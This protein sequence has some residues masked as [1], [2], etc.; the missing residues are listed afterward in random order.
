MKKNLL[1]FAS[2]ACAFVVTTTSP[3]FAQVATFTE[4]LSQISFPLSDTVM[5]N[6]N[7]HALQATGAAEKRRAK[8]ANNKGGSSYREICTVAHYMENPP[9][10]TWQNIY[11]LVLQSKNVKAFVINFN[12]R[13]PAG[14]I[15]GW[16][17]SQAEKG[18]AA[19]LKKVRPNLQEFLDVFAGEQQENA[20]YVI[21]W[22]PDGNMQVV[23]PDGKEK[24]IS[25]AAFA[26]FW[27]KLW[28]GEKSQFERADFVNRIVTL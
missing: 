12:Q 17:S 15:R 11:D 13:I 16:F 19:A 3:A 8:H 25:N 9:N 26:P 5:F 27:W 14:K 4:P 6:G 20:R 22:L 10:G 21:R 7:T 28:L 24:L 1:P 23:M 18:D 2:L